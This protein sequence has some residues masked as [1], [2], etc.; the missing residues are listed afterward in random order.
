MNLQ[1][2][3]NYILFFLIIFFSFAHKPAIA[4]LQNVEFSKD[5]FKDKKKELGEA[6]DNLSKGD[7][8][9][10]KENG[11]EAE[12]LPFY[13]K[14]Q[15][16]NPD[17]A[18]LN[19]KIAICYMS[20]YKHSNAIPYFE[21]AYLI[22]RTI[23]PDL[24][25]L[26]G[27]ALHLDYKFD[28]AIN[29]YKEARQLFTAK[30]L[31]EEKKGELMDRKVAECLNGKELVKTKTRCFIDNAGGSVNS[32]FPDYSPIITADESFMVF[33]SK[34]DNTT[35]G[36]IDSRIGKYFED[37]YFSIR[38]NKQ[39]TTALNAG[40]PLNS[41]AHDATVG[42]S[43]DGQK[44]LVYYDN[45]KNSGDIYLSTLKGEQ[46]SKPR[47]I[48]DNINTEFHEAVACFS[49]DGRSL[50]FV[51]NKPGG[52]GGSDIYVSH[53]IVNKKKEEWGPAVN[54]GSVINTPLDET[55]V[56][57]SPNSRTLYFS[58]KGH[59]TMGG[60]DI[61]KTEYSG[62]SW[63]EPENIGFPVNTPDDDV[64]FSISA[65]GKY[66]YYASVRPEGY[67]DLDIYRISFLG[68]EKPRINS[69]EDNLLSVIKEPVKAKV[70]EPAVDT[71][72]QK[73]TIFKGTIIDEITLLPIEA[74]IELT[75]NVKNTN[76][77]SFESNAKTG[78]FLVVLASGKNYGIAVQAEGYLFHSENFDIPDT[79]NYKEVYKEIK[80][81]KI[82][83]GSKIILRNIFFDFDK[84][85]LRPESSA[86][87]DRLIKLLTDLPKM[88]IE[89]SG[90]TDNKG[91]SDYN[92]KLSYERAKTVVDYLVTKGITPNRLTYNGYGFDQPV[93]TND[94]DE[95]RQLNRRTEFKILE[96]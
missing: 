61:F 30:E 48:G 81:K 26:Y 43:P 24:I 46:W 8:L 16:F 55:G 28:E 44:L 6:K 85:T 96:N 91:S 20:L 70:I 22:N 94:T 64:F 35:G 76:I 38:N 82:A 37:I 13:L 21:K 9:I 62:I 52:F 49:P 88:K 79:A 65:N 74:T 51:S 4:Q 80:L 68:P 58:S 95:G 34:R 29:K 60:Y 45:K 71:K 69:N 1:I 25:M 57:M 53:L 7:R 31:W 18:L 77:A 73:L 63:S 92:K 54:L 14:A 10:E 47:N 19:Y 27:R 33:T 11:K 72:P 87:L 84:S 50:Y 86:E 59:N 42:M 66:G 12:A 56:F 93:A 36:K 39:W 83:V 23:K 5:N 3:K 15:E 17:N 40:K 89:I 78:K 67:G 2:S 32:P 75:D 90:H 41:E